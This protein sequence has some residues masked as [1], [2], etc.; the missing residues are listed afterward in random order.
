MDYSILECT[1]LLDEEQLH[2]EANRY[3]AFLSDCCNY[4]VILFS[5]AWT[6]VS[7]KHQ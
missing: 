4:Q 2:F 1:S 3:T 7:A 5:A 6:S